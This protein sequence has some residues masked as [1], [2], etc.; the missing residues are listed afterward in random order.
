MNRKG[1]LRTSIGLAALLSLLVFFDG[2]AQKPK[3]QVVQP[4]ADSLEMAR[5]VEENSAEY[6][7]TEAMQYFLSENYSKALRTLEESRKLAPNNSAIPYQMAR[8]YLKMEDYKNAVRLIQQALN[9]SKDNPNYL[10]LLAE[11]YEKQERY[12]EAEKI[13][14]KLVILKPNEPGYYYDLANAMLYQ[15]KFKEAIRIYDELE[16]KVGLEPAV[17]QRK[18]KLYLAMNQPEGALKE[19][20]KLI[21]AMPDDPDAY[22]TQVELLMNTRRTEEARK[23]IAELENLFPNEPRVLLLSADLAKSS[24]KKEAQIRALEKAFDYP[25]LEIELRLQVLSDLYDQAS[26][27]NDTQLKTVLLSLSEKTMQ[28]FPDHPQ[29]QGLYAA[30]LL[31]NGKAAEAKSYY[32]KAVKL[33]GDN[34]QAWVGLVRADLMLQNY[35]DLARHTEQAIEYYPNNATFWFYNGTAHLVNRNY[36]EAVASLEQSRLLAI[37]NQELLQ[38]I[39]PQ[40]GDAYNGQKQYQKSDKAY[41][42]ALTYDINNRYVLNNYSYYLSLRRENL[43]KAKELSARLIKL[44]PDNP[45]YL[46]THGWVLY[47][48]GEYAA[49]LPLLEKAARL[50]PSNPTILEHYGDV[51]YKVGR[52]EEALKYWQLA[53]KNGTGSQWLD[54]KIAEKKLFE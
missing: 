46:D 11:I 2:R 23:L 5:E 3:K 8:T 17:I 7:F 44:E 50:N 27:T 35:K 32:E 14:A 47:V 28:I 10:S 40:L 22:I 42:E 33:N 48:R 36:D 12:D 16:K 25:Q 9:L 29:M 53:K 18:Q 51:L 49:A 20:R 21:E 31:E 13:F 24:G 30:I 34:Y 15:N 19:G 4:P 52:N 41:E 45:T 37:G 54:R 26:A 38:N 1:L 6:F 39:Y 43:D